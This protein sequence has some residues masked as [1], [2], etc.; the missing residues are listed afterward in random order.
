[1]SSLSGRNTNKNIPKFPNDIGT[2]G[3]YIKLKSNVN[4]GFEYVDVV[5][6]TLPIASNGT[7]GGVKID[8]N[9]L[10]IDSNTGVLSA[11]NTEYTAGTNISITNDVISATNTEY[12][13]GSNIS[14]T[15]DVI[16]ATNTEYTAGTNISITNDVISATTVSGITNLDNYSQDNAISINSEDNTIQLKTNST[17][18]LSI[19][20]DGDVGI[21]VTHTHGKLQVGGDIFASTN[22]TGT[23]KTANANVICN[24][25]RFFHDTENWCIGVGSSQMFYRTTQGRGHCFFGPDFNNN[26][27][28]MI[29]RTGTQGGGVIGNVGIG[30]VL[31]TE[32]LQ[33]NGNIK[34]TDLKFQYGGSEVTLS[35]IIPS[36]NELLPTVSSTAGQVLE[37][38]EVSTDVYGRRW[39]D[40]PTIPS[41]GYTPNGTNYAVALTD[42]KMFVN[43]PDTAI[44]VASS[45]DLGGIKLGFS[46]TGTTYAVELDTNSKAY[47]DVPAVTASS[48]DIG[49]IKIGFASTG[50]KYAV[51]LDTD[52]K[53]HVD[54]PAVTASSADLGGIKIGFASTGSKYAVELDTDSKAHVDVPA[55]I[56]TT[57]VLGG[58][59]VGSNLSI[60]LDGTL[61]ATNTEYTEG[62]GIDIDTTNSNAISIDLSPYSVASEI[63]LTSSTDDLILA[64]TLSTKEIQLN[65]D[66][67][68]KFTVANGLNTSN[69]LRVEYDV[70]APAYNSDNVNMLVTNVTINGADSVVTIRG[71]RRSSTTAKTCQL[72]FENLDDD[73][74]TP[75]IHTLGAI[76]C[77][78][79]DFT[80]NV[81]DLKFY[82]FSDGETEHE[83]LKLASDGNATFGKGCTATDFTFNITGGTS[84]VSSLYANALTSVPEASSADLGGIKLGF[85]TTGT[86]YAV[87]LDTNSKAYVDVPIPMATDATLGG[88]IIDGG[89]LNINASGKL[90]ATIVK[91][92]SLSHVGVFTLQDTTD[93][94]TATDTLIRWKPAITGGS[95]GLLHDQDNAIPNG[96]LFYCNDGDGGVYNINVQIAITTGT[97]GRSV[98]VLELRTF[99]GG[100]NQYTQGTPSR[101]YFIGSG[102]ARMLNGTN[103]CFYGGSIQITMEENDQFQIVSTSKYVSGSGT[104]E[105]NAGVEATRLI[106][107]RLI[108]D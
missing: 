46:T 53:A 42:N 104:I 4:D 48:A 77:V 79:N 16:S 93:L 105:L 81:G 91:K 57:S 15:N 68:T 9:N 73:S 103:K 56:A 11:T 88:V 30:I 5:D 58:I 7:L 28:L 99:T 86:T 25:I 19:E 65:N 76:S 17:T 72:R 94:R 18:R 23:G 50:S 39:T 59:I 22:T 8:G 101:T 47:V 98:H 38:Y 60:T 55:T 35:N 52:S 14:I 6:F 89:N 100:S 24:Q 27:E 29:I 3:Q 62:D 44:T 106:I 82:T 97:P 78:V 49:G 34:C 1:M 66:G 33:V 20:N 90:S 83:T 32:K 45:A 21:G 80:T 102:Y 95:S 41:I 64:T 84:T 2:A 71:S 61:T 40:L 54:V 87:E 67:V 107:D 63:K 12:T 26:D 51:E 70:S 37:V 13:A 43:V 75:Q 69:K 85:S 96:T 31:P 92:Q 108:I 36:G 74:S 10:S